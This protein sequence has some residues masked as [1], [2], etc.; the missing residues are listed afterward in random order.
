MS[1]IFQRVLRKIKKTSLQSN[2]QKLYRKFLEEGD[3]CFDVGANIGER[4]AIFLQLGAKVIAVEPQP[5]C[6]EYLQQHYDKNPNVTVVPKGL[7][8]KPGILPMY[9]S[10]SHTI[11]TFSEQWQT[12]R[13][14]DY[15]WNQTHEVEVTTLDHLV[16]QFG[17]PKFCKIDVEGFELEVLMGLSKPIEYISFEFAMEFIDKADACTEHLMNLG[18]QHFNYALGDNLA[19]PNKLVF[20]SWKNGPEIMHSIKH[21]GIEKLWGDIYARY[22]P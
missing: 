11:S 10:D 7:A 6:V 15:E 1:N 14:K 18:Y 8:A 20:D 16:E 12:G 19:T 5:F 3:L 9:I 22:Q 2:L 21:Q 17:I 4:T 13:F